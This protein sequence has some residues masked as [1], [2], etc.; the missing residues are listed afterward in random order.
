V[1]RGDDAAD[2]DAADADAAEAAGF[3]AFAWA[4]AVD[5]TDSIVAASNPVIRTQR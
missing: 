4:E 5:V 3:A 2:T 1:K